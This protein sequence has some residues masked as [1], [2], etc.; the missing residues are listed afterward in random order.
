MYLKNQK[1]RQF[2]R[3]IKVF[4]LTVATTISWF[5]LIFTKFLN[6]DIQ[7]IG[8]T[9]PGSLSM[10][11]GPFFSLNVWG[12]YFRPV[13]QSLLLLILY[14]SGLT[15]LL[16]HI[17]TFFLYLLSV[18][19]LFEAA[20]RS[21]IPENAAFITALIFAVLPAHDINAGW[22][23]ATSD[24]LVCNFLLTL[25]IFLSIYIQKEKLAAAHYVLIAFLSLLALLSKELSY[26]G[27][28]IP[29]LFLV[30][31]TETKNFSRKRILLFSLIYFS[32]IPL[33]FLYRYF[34]IGSNLL[35]SSHIAHVT[36]KQL[37][38]N[39]FLYIPA[40]ILSP[41]NLEQLFFIAKNKTVL[42]PLITLCVLLVIVI[43]KVYKSFSNEE[44]RTLLKAALWF[45]I[46]IAPVLPVF[47]RWY[48]FTASVGLSIIGGMFLYKFYEISVPWLKKTGI[49]VF[50][51]SVLLIIYSN[52]IISFKWIDAGN[53]YDQ[54]VSAIKK[55]DIHDKEI[56]AWGV[57]D[58]YQRI[59]LMKLGVQEVFAYALGEKK[60][61]VESPLRAE[62]SN[63]HSTMSYIPLTDSSF[64][65]KLNGGRFLFLG[66][67]SRAV[68]ISEQDSLITP[69]YVIRVNTAVK[70][71]NVESIA[72]V[73]L[74]NKEILQRSIF[75]THDG[76]RKSQ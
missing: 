33:I 53:K 29:I 23:S 68:I 20:R 8:T 12:Y 72:E 38:I 39:F 21:R 76:V 58:K 67:R 40:A 1:I 15:P 50:T 41:D 51:I 7:I 18:I 60:I 19:L 3:I 35:T 43:I 70:E 25:Y 17:V 9:V 26:T 66:G 64:Q 45:C 65:M 27:F 5:P 71:N 48:V 54:Y 30:D 14:I 52:L 57:P 47:M 2:P 13:L 59:A 37:I 49:I 61:Q 62:I 44:K 36:V 24:L 73:T 74:H 46:C 4:I 56:Y 22:L 69:D 11:F 55:A 31:K 16:F 42:F 75:F 32:I 63:A 28:F 10:V 6:D 34:V